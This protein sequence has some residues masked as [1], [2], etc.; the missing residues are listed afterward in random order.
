MKTVN[1]SIIVVVLIFCSTLAYSRESII[2]LQAGD[3]IS[4]RLESGLS[5]YWGNFEGLSE[6]SDFSFGYVDATLGLTLFRERMILD[7]YYRKS[8]ADTKNQWEEMDQDLDRKEY[9][10]TFGFQATETFSP[11]LGIRHA[12]T[13]ATQY[14]V[15]G[16]THFIFETLGATLGLAYGSAQLK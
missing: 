11:F 2:D 9:N 13:D 14:E 4:L 8:I 1:T 16:T 3:A 12:K 10:V 6:G 7:L 15:F 5:H